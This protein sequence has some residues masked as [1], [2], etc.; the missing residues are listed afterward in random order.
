[1]PRAEGNGR[2]ARREAFDGTAAR[3][4][5]PRAYIEPI[6]SVRPSGAEP[7]PRRDAERSEAPSS[8]FTAGGTMSVPGAS[9][10][11]NDGAGHAL[12]ATRLARRVRRGA[13]SAIR[14]GT[15]PAGSDALLG[16]A[17][18]S[19]RLW[20]SAR[21]ALD[22]AAASGPRPPRWPRP[23]QGC[24]ATHRRPG[25]GRARAEV[26]GAQ[27]LRACGT[28]WRGQSTGTVRLVPA[29]RIPRPTY[30]PDDL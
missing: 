4:S 2:P 11:D 5:S 12:G 19:I 6:G 26:A 7:S 14:L 16:G 23:S 17:R 18:R 8:G 22:R 24:M 30:P 10:S 3:R 13:R 20:R 1:V 15:R 25:D 9:D 27:R 29:R 28:P 21:P